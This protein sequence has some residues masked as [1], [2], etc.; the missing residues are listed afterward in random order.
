MIKV[1]LC[2]LLFAL[3]NTVHNEKRIPSWAVSA[4]NNELSVYN[5]HIVNVRVP[6]QHSI[7]LLDHD[8]LLIVHMKHQSSLN[9]LRYSFEEEFIAS[10]AKQI[11][12][13]HVIFFIKL[14]NFF[15]QTGGSVFHIHSSQGLLSFSLYSFFLTSHF[16]SSSH[17]TCL[18]HFFFFCVFSRKLCSNGRLQTGVCVHTSLRWFR[19]RNKTISMYNMGF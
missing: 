10:V 7:F 3:L 19:L 8:Y 9:G 13:T 11:D 2:F 1:G 12:L 5:F 6:F 16:L 17:I 18:C 15:L 4:T 14:C